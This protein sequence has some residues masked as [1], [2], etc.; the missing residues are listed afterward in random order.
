MR[1]PH[2]IRPL[3]LELLNRFLQCIP[4]LLNQVTDQKESRPVVSVVTM[5]SD[6]FARLTCFF[7]GT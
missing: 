5:Y 3:L 1:M 4:S 6:S 7:A 2:P